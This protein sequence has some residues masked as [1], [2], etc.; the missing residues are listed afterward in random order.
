LL[1]QVAHEKAESFG[2]R[3][4]LIVGAKESQGRLLNSGLFVIGQPADN[5]PGAFYRRLENHL[6]VKQ[7]IPL[8]LGGQISGYRLVGT[9]DH[10]HKLYH[11]G[12]HRGRGFRKPFELVVGHAAAQG[13]N[14][15]VGS[16]IQAGHSLTGARAKGRKQT[17]RVVGILSPCRCLIDR[18]LLT[19]L[20]SIWIGHGIKLN[21]EKSVARKKD[22]WD[23][24]LEFV[25]RGDEKKSVPE[26]TAVLLKLRLPLLSREKVIQEVNKSPIA[27]AVSPAEEMKRLLTVMD[28]IVKL[29]RI[30]AYISIALAVIGFLVAMLSN[31]QTRSK[32]WLL[33]RSM[34]ASRGFIFFL[35]LGEGLLLAIF[36]SLLGL[37]IG[38]GTYVAL[39]A[40]GAHHNIVWL[41][42]KAWDFSEVFIIAHNLILGMLCALPSALTSRYRNLYRG[43]GKG[44]VP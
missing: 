5:I 4:D 25:R 44:L 40:L 36:A 11:A 31:L 6:L 26:I 8:L 13:L 18:L 14:L 43:L 12:F 29:V 10:Y 24:V 1:K 27:Q 20:E 19:Q 28:R 17:Y 23:R 34:G 38:H 37:A 2:N 16:K 32:D 7:A 15:K 33:M 3:V 21:A 42:V 39:A 9:D 41:P 30:I 35:V 22:I